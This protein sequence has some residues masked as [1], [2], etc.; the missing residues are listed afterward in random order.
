MS[1]I[2][3]GYNINQ[4]MKQCFNCQYW[5]AATKISP[6]FLKLLNQDIA[7]PAIVRNKLEEKLTVDMY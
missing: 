2:G 3:L 7:L 6:F 4:P 5:K 1:R